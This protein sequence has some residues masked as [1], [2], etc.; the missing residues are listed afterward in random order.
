MKAAKTGEGCRGGLALFGT[1]AQG[2]SAPFAV[3]SPPSQRALS[4]RSLLAEQQWLQQQRESLTT[5]ITTKTL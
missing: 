1:F 3:L 2:G 5:I 4:A